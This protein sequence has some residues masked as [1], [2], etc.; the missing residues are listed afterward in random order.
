L[1]GIS[2]VT[3]SEEEVKDVLDQFSLTPIAIV[4]LAKDNSNQLVHEN[5]KVTGIN[6]I[7]TPDL[8]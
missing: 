4:G 8:A 3:L 5:G 2:S 6:R 1:H 7:F